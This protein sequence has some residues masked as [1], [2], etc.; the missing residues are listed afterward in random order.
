MAPV[1]H[2]PKPFPSE[3]GSLCTCIKLNQIVLL[4]DHDYNYYCDEP[5]AKTDLPATEVLNIIL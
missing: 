5:T 2:S 3:L 1:D 4:T